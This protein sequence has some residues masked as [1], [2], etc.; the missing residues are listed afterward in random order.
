MSVLLN[1]SAGD[2]V[3]DLYT[4]SC[5][6]ATT[7]FLKLCQTKYY[8]N[9]LFYNV[10]QN[11]IA[12]TG[13]PT[14]TGKGGN[15][16]YGIL[17]GQQ[18]SYFK[19]EIVKG[20]KLN[21]VGMVGMAHSG[22]KEDSNRS[23][24]FIL[25]DLEQ[26]ENTHTIFGELAEGLDVL[27]K[28]NG[29]YCDEEGRP[30]QDV[31]IL[32]TYVLDDPFPDPPNLIIP[33]SSPER[34]YPEQERVKRRLAYSETIED[35]ADGK[36]AEEL[37]E[38]IRRKEAK[39]RA[40]VLEMTGDIP[41]ADVK[42]PDEVLF[43]C[44]LN[45]V[46][47]DEDLELIFSRF[48]TIKSC[49]VI[50]DFKTGES[51]N[52]AFIEFEAAGACIEAYEKMNNVLID[53]R[54]IK[55]DFSQSVSKLWNRFLLQPRKDGNST[56]KSAPKP[57]DKPSYYMRQPGME[58]LNHAAN[59][60]PAVPSVVSGPSSVTTD[61]RSQ[62]NHNR[63]R[64]SGG[65]DHQGA[66]YRR[67]DESRPR[68]EANRFGKRDRSR[69]RSGDRYDHRNET[70]QEPGRTGAD[71]RKDRGGEN[72]RRENSRDRY[73][74]R[75]SEKRERDS[76]DRQNRSRRSRSREDK[77]RKSSTQS[78]RDERRDRIGDRIGDRGQEREEIG[79]RDGDAR[80]RK[81]DRRS[82][83]PGRERGEDYKRRNN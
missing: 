28:I 17:E 14:G 42:P 77:D 22:G 62:K 4:D 76:R 31:R 80:D 2:L 51:L 55:V 18:T 74:S 43:V 10:Q 15:S 6:L 48:G 49:E 30:Y 34:E 56:D 9:C 27:E 65:S 23:Q 16:I 54:R 73:R 46:T 64:G 1:T 8:N 24:F 19:D 47:T 3:I 26:F 78:H 69:D 45:P 7:N 52:Y 79:H 66:Q 70:G 60:K 37:D 35:D 61:S 12:Q 44:K 72:S 58:N 67:Q 39:S 40:I 71:K 75:D 20:R 13:D 57:G 41:D 21:K 83:S 33:P 38:S 5:P 59:R 81:R 53:D 50:R 32:H 36:T 25:E 82:H 11:F 29:L 68:N 63:E